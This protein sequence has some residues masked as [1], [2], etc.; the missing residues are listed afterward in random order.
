MTDHSRAGFDEALMGVKGHGGTPLGTAVKAGI[1]DLEATE[2]PIAVIVFSDGKA[3]ESNVVTAAQ[4]MK[5]QYGDR[6]CIY[7]VLVGDSEFGKDL[8]EQIA[9]AGGCGFSTTADEISSPQAMADFVTTVFL[10][11]DCQDSDGDGVCDDEDRCLHTQKGLKVDETGCPLDSDGDGVPDH[12]DWC[13]DTPR[14]V[15]VDSNGCPLDS[16][17]DGVADHLDECPDTPKGFD[18]DYKGCEIL[19]RVHFD[20]DKD[21][22]KPQYH[23]ILDQAV[24]FLKRNPEVI[25]EIHG[26]TD[27][28]GTAAYNQKLSERRAGAVLQYLVEKGIDKDR[29][30]TAGHGFTQPIETN[31]TK[32]G[33]AMNRRAELQPIR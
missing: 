6:V 27:N 8:M 16:D 15:K 17:G 24:A 23:S 32:A 18:V 2:G 25:M 14:W 19:G 11:R 12:L 26:H 29:F 4:A 22:I 31:R 28:E 7:T 21:N 13:P 5:R 33:R 3:T 1:T 20:F 30:F 9:D 10:E